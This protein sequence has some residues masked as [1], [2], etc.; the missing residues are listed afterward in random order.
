MQR[1]AEAN[2]PKSVQKGKEASNDCKDAN[3]AQNQHNKEGGQNAESEMKAVNQ[4]RRR[5]PTE[6]E[7]TG[8]WFRLFASL[9]VSNTSGDKSS[10]AL[11]L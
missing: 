8:N 6:A 11:A 4:L 2:N 5:L 1:L 9:A 7:R 10:R 3:S